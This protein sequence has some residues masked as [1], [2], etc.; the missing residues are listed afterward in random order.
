MPTDFG[1]C[2]FKSMFSSLMIKKNVEQNSKQIF[3]LSALAKNKIIHFTFNK[4]C[5]VATVFHTKYRLFILRITTSMHRLQ[6][7]DSL[8]YKY[9]L[10][11]NV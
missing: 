2:R 4:Y 7:K 10:P 1:L 5:R 9:V 6:Y 3:G 8:L 11:M